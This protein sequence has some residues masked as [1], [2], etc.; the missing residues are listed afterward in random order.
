MDPTKNLAARHTSTEIMHFIYFAEKKIE[1]FYD[2][3]VNRTEE[4]VTK[5]TIKEV[6]GKAEA[7][8]KGKIGKVLALLGL[9]D[10]ELEVG[11]TAGGKIS[12]ERE[13]VEAF[14]QA[15]KLKALLL[16]LHSEDRLAILAQDALSSDA[17]EEGMAV[18]LYGALKTDYGRRSED[19][20]WRTHSAILTGS[21]GSFIIEVQ[22][23]TTYMESEG[24]WLRW[25][26]PTK[27][28]G[29]GTLTRVDMGE[30]R[31]ELDPIALAYAQPE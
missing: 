26:H 8:G 6:E 30:L 18:V 10:V 24:A 29:F 7:K 21:T 16:K 2:F 1:R 9:A 13:V 25:S 3:L 15:Q 17:P 14:T 28:V 31:L 12:I 27:M 5:K 23:S 22:A 20:I 19:D 11:V 4:T